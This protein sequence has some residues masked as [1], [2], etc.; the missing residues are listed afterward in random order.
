M[1]LSCY[2]VEWCRS[3]TW[4]FIPNIR[5]TAS[6]V[7]DEQRKLRVVAAWTTRSASTLLPHNVTYLQL[8]ASLL[9]WIYSCLATE[10]A[11]TQ[12]MLMNQRASSR[13]RIHDFAESLPSGWCVNG[14]IFFEWPAACI[15]AG[16]NAV[17]DTSYH[18]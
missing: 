17:S 18:R 7:S 10:A 8:D 4:I 15:I 6:E 3:C 9:D 11:S 5:Q 1:Q 14:F 2:Y 13:G 12:Q 16:H